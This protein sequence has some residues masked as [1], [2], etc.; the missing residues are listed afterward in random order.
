MAGIDAGGGMKGG[1][2]D[3]GGEVRSEVL[4]QPGSVQDGVSGASEVG[5]AK[6]PEGGR[7]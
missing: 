4:R 1:G 6:G 3:D 7:H 5:T 2:M